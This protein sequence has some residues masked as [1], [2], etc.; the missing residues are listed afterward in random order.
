MAEEYIIGLDLNK[1]E[2]QL[3]RYDAGKD[4]A[5]SVMVT[6]GGSRE[7]FPA[8]LA[9]LPA[10]EKWKYGIEA[11][12]FIAHKGALRVDDVFGIASGAKDTELDGKIFTPEFILSKFIALSLTSA[13]ITDPKE[14]L[15]SLVV[16]APAITR[17]FAETAEKA[18]AI[19]GLDGRR[20]QIMD[21]AESFF[22]HTF[23]QKIDIKNRD[24]ALYY[25]PDEYTVSFLSIGENSQTKPITVFPKV[26]GEQVLP[27]EPDE[28]DAAFLDFI[29]ETTSRGEY[30]AAFLV[31]S[32]FDRSWSRESLAQL[33]R[34]KRKVFYGN[35]L[36]AKGA[37]FAALDRSG[38][39][40]LKD[41]LYIGSDLVTENI[42]MEM[43]IDGEPGYKP[44]I[45]AGVNWYKAKNEIE[46]ILNDERD[47]IFRTS[48][49][50]DG[51]RRKFRMTLPELPVRPPK[52]TR[53]RLSI[54]YEEA[55]KCVITVTDMGFGEF[56]PSS[57]LTWTETLKER[58]A[59][60]RG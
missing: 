52:M 35:N 53:L 58:H 49:M 16:T 19:L 21:H 34:G 2:A 1:Y 17:E 10:D 48:S 51:I 8:R 26:R 54:K 33:C 13:G 23:Y 46:F 38:D 60:E 11:D 32:G 36:F 27:F 37:C 55:G 50:T 41:V 7:S 6:A 22:F 24:A 29:K 44:L 12:Y 20:S 3:C 15:L 45:R 5:E 57:G 25:F 56:C 43:L 28:R 4:D 39:T 47:V 9:Y 30:S 31:G 18:F 40:K 14:E 59:E 42:G